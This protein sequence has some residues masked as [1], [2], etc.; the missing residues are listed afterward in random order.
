M[1]REPSLPRVPS[2]LRGPECSGA[3]SV[4]PSSSPGPSMSSNCT[5]CRPSWATRPLGSQGSRERPPD[6]V[7]SAPMPSRTASREGR[8]AGSLRRQARTRSAMPSGTPV[9]SGSSSAM[10]NISAGI[11]LS[12]LPKG[13]DPVA[14]YES[15]EPRQNTSEAGVIRSPRTC[16]GAMKPG[17]PIMTPVRVSSGVSPS[18]ARAIPKS[19][20]RGP[21]MVTM[22]LEGLRS[23]WTMPAAW[24]SWRACASPAARMRTDRSGSGPWSRPTT[25]WRL[26][27]ATYPVATHG[28]SASVSAS[29]TGAVQ[30]PPTRRAAATSCRNR[31]RNSSRAASSA[32]TSF[33][34]TV[35]PRSDRAR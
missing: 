18:S 34:A 19:M 31:C 32:R 4:S 10:R 29:R 8:A 23:R 9:R 24:M 21:S 3:A 26:G 16:S 5:A 13:S 15:T 22:T 30:W 14:A 1:L 6:T 20:T 27:P 7:S 17:D 12:A 35:R 2:V 25:C 11:P 28:I 33:T